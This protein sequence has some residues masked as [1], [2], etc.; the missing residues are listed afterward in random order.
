MEYTGFSKS[1]RE[2]KEELSS[3]DD[4]LLVPARESAYGIS[5]WAVEVQISTIGGVPMFVG[6]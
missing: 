5:P 3:H 2:G 6:I 1:C 4:L